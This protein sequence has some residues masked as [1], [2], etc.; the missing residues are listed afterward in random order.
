MKKDERLFKQILRE[1]FKGISRMLCL[2]KCK[3]F[4]KKGKVENEVRL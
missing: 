3:N 2:K 4:N 1:S